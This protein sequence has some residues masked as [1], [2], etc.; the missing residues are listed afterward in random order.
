MCAGDYDDHFPKADSSP[1]AKGLVMPYIKSEA[2]FKS[3]SG[4]GY[5]YNTALSGALS[6]SIA[7]PDRILLV[8]QEIPFPNGVRAVGFADGHAKNVDAG[9]WDRLWSME[10]R[11]RLKAK[12]DTRAA[13]AAIKATRKP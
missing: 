13:A 8:W 10:Q 3:P 2:V 9:E 11:R 4:G 1:K 5:L 12:M 6:T 7:Q